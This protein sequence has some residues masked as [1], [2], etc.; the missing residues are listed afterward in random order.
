MTQKRK[1][2][3]YIILVLDIVFRLRRVLMLKYSRNEYETKVNSS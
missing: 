2:V 1:K 3:S